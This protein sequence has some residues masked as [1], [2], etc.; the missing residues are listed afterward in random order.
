MTELILNVLF[1]ALVAL[2]VAYAI[3]L[4]VRAKDY[5]TVAYHTYKVTIL[6]TYKEKLEYALDLAQRNYGK[7]TRMLN[8]VRKIPLLGRL[9]ARRYEA[10][11]ATVEYAIKFNQEIL[12][13]MAA[14]TVMG[15]ET[16]DASFRFPENV[17]VH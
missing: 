17:T 5:I 3:K 6:P 10:K 8:I 2:G 14:A 16:T 13:S 7:F 11:L 4:T 12:D 1:F 9:L 15:T